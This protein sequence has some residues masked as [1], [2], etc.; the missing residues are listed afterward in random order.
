MLVGNHNILYA[1]CRDYKLSG[2][3]TSAVRGGIRKRA[4][5]RHQY[6]AA[7]RARRPRL[8]RTSVFK[9]GAASLKYVPPCG[10]GLV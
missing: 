8:G 2:V 6:L 4:R 10:Y 7:R 3:S 5:R 9:G 1:D